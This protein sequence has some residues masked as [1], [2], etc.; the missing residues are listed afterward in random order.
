MRKCAAVFL[1]VFAIAIQVEAAQVDPMFRRDAFGVKTHA[2][3]PRIADRDG[4]APLVTLAAAAAAVPDELDAIRRW[5]EQRRS[6]ARNGFTRSIGG[7]LRVRVA[8]EARNGGAMANSERG[9]LV[10]GGSVRVEGAYRLRLH[11]TN[12]AVP[13]GTTFWVYGRSGEPI[14]FG[15]ELIDPNGE[16]YT[17]S[18]KGDLARLEMELPPNS[19]GGSFDILDVVE[20]VGPGLVENDTPSCLVDG[21]CVGNS[22][23]SVIDLYRRAVA[24]LQYVKNGGS[25]VCTGG[26][27]NDTNSTG[28][29]Y[30][31]TANHCFATQTSATSLEAF[32]DYKTSSCSGAF[33]DIET[34]PRA[35]GATL[36]ATNTGSDFTF[37]R[38]NSV[39]SS[40]VFLGWSSGTVAAGT[41]LHRLSHPFPSAF[42]QPAPQAYS[43]TV[44][45]TTSNTC[46]ARPRPNYLYSLM[47][48]GGVYGGSSGSPV[49]L[50][51]GHVVGQLFGSCGPNDPA[52]GCDVTNMTVDGAFSTTY[53]SISSFLGTG[54][55]GGG[56][57]TP[58]SNTA[59]ML[60]NRFRVTVRFRNGF[61]NGTA[62][63][64][65]SVK[66]VTGF[67]SANFET[68]F[69]FFNSESNIEMMVKILDQ[70]NTNGAGQPTIAVLFGSATPLRVELT[71]TDTLRGT[72]KSY[73][74]AF[75]A[76]QGTTDF[77]AFLK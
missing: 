77:E 14:A 70:G 32:F 50:A 18:I 1:A 4:V 48:D 75:G 15:T 39:P 67:A 49:I 41:V 31:L 56:G 58:N 69:F 73:T 6:P 22:T 74:S 37:V 59:C 42:S 17:P 23:L 64:N 25:F 36:L 26:L 12:V 29:P 51:T 30:L 55:N 19:S 28:T 62:D 10:W 3:A 13:V 44:V 34:F 21:T 57:C 52:A 61:D 66:P 33:P 5:N 2:A 24:H 71:I 38:L 8:A 16:L 35:N 76:M 68:A 40:R 60:N 20:L 47:D 45:T 72:T 46:S 7:P 63:T 54:S 43:S 53:P 27:L 9:T 11:L 65:A